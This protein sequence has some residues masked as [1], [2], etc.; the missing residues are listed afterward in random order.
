MQSKPTLCI[1]LIVRPVTIIKLLGTGLILTLEKHS[2]LMLYPI[3][4]A[5]W[6]QGFGV[7]VGNLY[8]KFWWLWKPNVFVSTKVT[9]HF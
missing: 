8:S 4:T 2:I 6:L 7:Q 9:D 5:S 1:A 3:N